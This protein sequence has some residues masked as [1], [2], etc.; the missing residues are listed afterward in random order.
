MTLRTRSGGIACVL[1]LL[2]GVALSVNVT[3]WQPAP[4]H[5]TAKR[6]IA[7]VSGI[8]DLPLPQDWVVALSCT[9]NDAQLVTL[10]RQLPVLVPT[11]ALTRSAQGTASPATVLN[12]R[13]G[14]AV[15]LAALL[16]KMPALVPA[17][18]CRAAPRFGV[19]A[20]QPAFRRATVPWHLD[21]DDQRASVAGG[22]NAFVPRN[23]ATGAGIVI[24]II[25]TG[26]RTTHQ[27]FG[28]R[29]S[30]ILDLVGGATSNGDCNGTFTFIL[31]FIYISIYM[32]IHTNNGRG[33]QPARLNT[34]RSKCRSVKPCAR[35]P[36]VGRRASPQ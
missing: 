3:V 33:D 13:C 30:V 17:S 9:L 15:T 14:A 22:D 4:R 2:L 19:M 31:L 18:S 12:V 20:D 29:A 24:Y 6:A 35:H 7:E 5:M 10:N 32:H 1:A 34:P 27:E 23:G 11:C 21:R 8:R 16:A 25:D 28:G 36:L 26:V